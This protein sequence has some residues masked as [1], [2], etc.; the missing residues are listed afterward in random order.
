MAATSLCIHRFGSRHSPIPETE[1][2]K[3]SRRAF[4]LC[5]PHRAP[6]LIA[7]SGSECERKITSLERNKRNVAVRTQGCC[8]RQGSPLPSRW[9]SR[10]QR[11]AQ[12]AV[13][14]RAACHESR[15]FHKKAGGE[16]G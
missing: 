2:Q 8:V 1:L 11:A 6:K 13:R 10:C 7:P 12:H 15:C 4:A 5:G 3:T 16:V 14:K 9:R